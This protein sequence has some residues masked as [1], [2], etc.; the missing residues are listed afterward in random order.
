MALREEGAQEGE[1]GIFGGF[2]AMFG[3]R[4]FGGLRVCSGR[5]QGNHAGKNSQP[6]RKHFSHIEITSFRKSG[7]F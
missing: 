7:F 1:P 2:V 4:G 5:R 3:S 6:V